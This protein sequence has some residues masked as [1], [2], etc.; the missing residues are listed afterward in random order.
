MKTPCTHR[1]R[2]ARRGHRL[3]AGARPAAPE[4]IRPRAPPIPR[5]RS[6]TS[7]PYSGPASAYA[8]DR[9]RRSR[10]TSTR[11]TPRAASTAARSTSSPMTTA[12]ARRKTVEQARKLVESDEVLLIFQPLG[13]ASNAAIQKYMNAKKAPQLFV[14]TG[15]THFGDNPEDFPWT[16]GWQPNYQS[17][18]R[19]YAKY[20]LD[21]K[22][23]RQDRR[24]V[25]E[26]RLRQGPA[27]GPQG[28][29]RRQGVR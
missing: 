17:E 5:S 15:A 22:P 8:P 10:P 29:A 19:I 6:A 12:T 9:A 2:R 4:E 14:A 25:P 24:A 16:M 7:C 1:P 26:R 13:T 23:D 3:L 27:E 18:G 28:R 21:T 11:S 20:I